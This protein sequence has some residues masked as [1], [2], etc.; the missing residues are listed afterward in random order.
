MFLGPF[1]VVFHKD[2]MFNSGLLV[3]GIQYVKVENDLSCSKI[4]FGTQSNPW[5]LQFKW[6]AH[7]SGL[8]PCLYTLIPHY[9]SHWQ[10]LLCSLSSKWGSRAIVSG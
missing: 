4:H 9:A 3:S 2:N 6:P 5:Q 7:A 1:S 8:T 10:H